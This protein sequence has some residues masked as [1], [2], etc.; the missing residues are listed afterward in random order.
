MSE[1]FLNHFDDT[2]ESAV[3]FDMI[4]HPVDTDLIQRAK[5]NG[6]RTV[7]GLE[8]LIAQA[9]PAFEKFFGQLAPREH[10]AELR[11]RLIA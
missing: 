11:E 8:M 2:L 7:D 6:L 4:T 9:A 10:D 5:S 1:I 3:V